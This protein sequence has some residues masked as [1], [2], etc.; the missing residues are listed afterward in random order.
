MG[1]AQYGRSYEKRQ[2]PG[3]RDYYWALW[4]EPEQPP[5]HSADVTELRKGN[6]TLTPLKFDLTEKAL[7]DE[8]RSWDLKG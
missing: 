3:G 5:A 2:D 7:L 4:S 8:M 1:L 6:V